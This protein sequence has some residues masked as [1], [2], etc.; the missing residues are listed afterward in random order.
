MQSSRMK[1]LP[2]ALILSADE[3]P[4]RDEAEQYGAKLAAAGIRTTVRRLP[5]FELEQPDARCSCARKETV[6]QEIAAFI[7][8][9]EGPEHGL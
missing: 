3:D 5:P 9:L 2:P 7:H 1:G 8:G 4:L 6:L